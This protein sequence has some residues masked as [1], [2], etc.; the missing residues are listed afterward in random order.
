[1]PQPSHAHTVTA[2][3]GAVDGPAR[4]FLT[5]TLGLEEY[6]IDILKVQEI[7]GYDA[8]T[9]LAG[10]PAFIKGVINLRG[11]IVPIVDLRIKFGVGAVEYT[12]FTVVIILH[13]AGRVVGAVVDGVSD[14][15]ALQAGQIHPAPDF[16]HQVGAAYL[17]GLGSTENRMLILLDI[18][19]LMLSPDMALVDDA[20]AA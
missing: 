8:V 9:T 19:K 3:Q 16:S 15:V 18:E 11:T 5:F 2:Q 4:E 1:V 6:A 13:V 20:V 12:P 7:R 10:A 14:V 17:L